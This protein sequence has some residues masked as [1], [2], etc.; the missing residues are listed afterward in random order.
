MMG[1]AGGEKNMFMSCG[2]EAHWEDNK[3]SDLS[4]HECGAISAEAHFW[5]VNIK[6]DEYGK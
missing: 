1:R 5:Q 3:S 6:H 2:C 4:L